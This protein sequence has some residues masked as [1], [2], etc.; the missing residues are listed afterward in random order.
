VGIGLFF[1]GSGLRPGV[2]LQ[3]VF[4][5]KELA[6]QHYATGWNRAG[7]NSGK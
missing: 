2:S 6:S 4:L 1:R 3:A 5:V 7:S